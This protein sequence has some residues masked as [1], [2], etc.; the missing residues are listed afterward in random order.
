LLVSRVQYDRFEGAL[1]IAYHPTAI[2]ALTQNEEEEGIAGTE[3]I[4]EN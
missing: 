1:S 4:S 3:H 2:T